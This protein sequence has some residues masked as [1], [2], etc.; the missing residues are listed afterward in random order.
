MNYLP[1]LLLFLL[2]LLLSLLLF[3]LLLQVEPDKSN[4]YSV[5]V[6]RTKNGTVVIVGCGCDNKV[7]DDKNGELQP[8]IVHK[9]VNGSDTS[10]F[11]PKRKVNNCKMV[12][13][14]WNQ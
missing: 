4:L 12:V 7:N 14:F 10:S 1:L 11:L 5:I 13:G 3:L 8:R 6:K 2:L 9:G